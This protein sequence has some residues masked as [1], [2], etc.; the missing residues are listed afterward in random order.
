M[1]FKPM[2]AHKGIYKNGGNHYPPQ[3]FQFTIFSQF[4]FTNKRNQHV[5][6]T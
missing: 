2:S 5:S 4:D 6:N 1:M 3:Q